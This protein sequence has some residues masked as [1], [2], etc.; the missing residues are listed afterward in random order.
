TPPAGSPGTTGFPLRIIE[1]PPAALLA[2]LVGKQGMVVLLAQQ[3]WLMPPL[4]SMQFPA[5]SVVA[6]AAPVHCALH[7]PLQESSAVCGPLESGQGVGP[8]SAGA[9]PVVS[10]SLM[11]SV[12]GGES[13]TGGQLLDRR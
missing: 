10:G 5:A 12:V 3:S 7:G 4:A 2:A 6:Q 9:V 1:P 13:P 8:V 11:S